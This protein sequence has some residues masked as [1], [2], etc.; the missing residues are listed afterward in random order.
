MCLLFH[1]R[2]E[3]LHILDNAA[4][5][6]GLHLGELLLG[7][8]RSISAQVA[9]AAFRAHQLARTRQAK[10]LGCRLVSLKFE[11]AR[12]GFARHWYFSFQTK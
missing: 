9:L 5:L 10:S 7:A 3:T 11:L 4:T 2:R 6:D 12:F 8:L 1:V